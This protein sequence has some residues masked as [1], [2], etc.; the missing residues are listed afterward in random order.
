MKTIRRFKK[1]L[2]KGILLLLTAIISLYSSS[3]VYASS[4]LDE[5]TDEETPGDFS[6]DISYSLLRGS[7][8]NFGSM[9]ISRLSSNE[10][11]IY[12]LTQGHHVSDKV[13]LTVYLEQKVDGYYQTYRMWEFTDEDASNLD[14]SISVIV[15]KGYYYRA[16]GYH[17]VTDDGNRESTTTLTDGILVN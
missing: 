4:L 13:W 5:L 6:E 1:V 15:P 9:K 10:V 14:A 12:G 17:A 16:R 7:H 3:M 11:N 2:T 8:L